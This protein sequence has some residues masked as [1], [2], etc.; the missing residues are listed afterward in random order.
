MNRIAAVFAGAF[1]LVLSV[2]VSSMG[3]TAVAQTTGDHF[4]Y[5]PLVVKPSLPEH[6]IIFASDRDNARSVYD[7]FIMNS[8]GTGVKN[9]TNTPDVSE[10]YPTWSPNGAMIA[11]LSGDQGSVEVFIMSHTGGDKRNVSNASSVN[12]RG[13]VWSPDSS[14]LA[15]LSDRDDAEGIYDIF[16]VNSDGIGL[17]NLTHSTDSDERSF[18][19]SPDGTKIVYLADLSLHPMGFIGH[20]M[21]MNADGTNKTTI[22]T[23]N[24]FNMGPVWSSEGSKIAFI[25]MGFDGDCL[26]LMNPDGTNQNCLTSSSI[27]TVNEGILWNSSGSQILFKG[28]EAGSSSVDL[29]V[30]DASNGDFTNVTVN[31]PGNGYPF[32]SMNWSADDMQIVYDED[33]SLQRGDIS[34][35]GVNGSDYNNLTASDNDDDRWPNWSPVPLP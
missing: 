7:I 34:V 31:V 5:L 27:E 32:E 23:N 2:L 24:G 12:A 6:K 17:T 26:A 16:V 33:F 14:R 35:V 15:F 22:A 11:Y 13:L 10:S 30:I 20:V 3:R 8:D 4:V 19:W 28:Q 29:F 21:M 9:L 25:L 1:L 18:D